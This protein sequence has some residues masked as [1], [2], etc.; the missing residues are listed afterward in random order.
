MASVGSAGRSDG[1]RP[2]SS[3]SGL[4][5]STHSPHDPETLTQAHRR[6]LDRL[7]TELL[8]NNA[9]FTNLLRRSMTSIDHLSGLMQRLSIIQ[10]SFDS[11]TDTGAD[12]EESHCAV[13]ARR[14]TG[15]L[16]T[17][18]SKVASE[19]QALTEA[20]RAIDAAR[21]SGRQYKGAIPT[22][23][24]DGFIPWTGG[25]VDRLLLKFDYG[26]KDR[27]YWAAV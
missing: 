8:L 7:K 22:M 12:F 20:L 15:Q 24:H 14:I 10:Q 19:V 5:S 23:E 9:D 1:S 17:S 18:R 27:M 2:T 4:D 16:K 26:N 6:Y 11:Q 3:P 21:T 25:G 13:E